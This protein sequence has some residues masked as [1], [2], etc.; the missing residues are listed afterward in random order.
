MHLPIKMPQNCRNKVL[1]DKKK[2]NKQGSAD[3]L[4]VKMLKER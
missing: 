3:I 2:S 4:D 1:R